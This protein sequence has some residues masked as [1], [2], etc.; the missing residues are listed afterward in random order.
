M[1]KKII[2]SHELSNKVHLVGRKIPSEIPWWLSA[3]DI[4]ALPTY[5]EGS[6]NV[7]R[8]AMACGL[9]V[10]ATRVGGVPEVVEDGESGILVDK[11]DVTSLVEAIRALINSPDMRKKM[12]KRGREIIEDNFTWNKNAKDLREIYEK[13]L[14]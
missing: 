9:P 12:G 6:P 11:K 13:V 4:F 2:D 10:V 14:L 3:A 5:H 7:V 8:E 1:L